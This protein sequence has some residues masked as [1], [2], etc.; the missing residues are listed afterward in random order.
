MY[1]VGRDSLALALDTWRYDPYVQRFKGIVSWEQAGIWAA[2]LGLTEEAVE[3]NSKKLAD[4]PYRFPA[5]WGPGHDWVPDH[6]WGG[7]GM[8]GLQEMLMKEVGDSLMLFPAWPRQ[9]DVHFRLRRANGHAIEVKL[10]GGKVRVIA[11]EGEK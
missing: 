4:G 8:I 7:S 2:C 1:G 3:W 6:N 5:F 9:W 10:Q 11:G